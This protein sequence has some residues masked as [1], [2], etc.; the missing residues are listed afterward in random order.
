MNLW[1]CGIKGSCMRLKYICIINPEVLSENT[2]PDFELKYIDIGNVTV[3][4]GIKELQHLRFKDAPSR[5]R[6]VVRKGDTIVSTVRT[7]LRAI[8][9]IDS[10]VSNE[11]AS[12]GFAV[13]RPTN[14]INSRFLYRVAQSKPFVESVVALSSG[15]NYPAINSTT[16]A[17]IPIPLP[18]IKEQHQIASFLDHK[19]AKIDQLIQEKRELIELLKKKK[20]ALITKCVTKGLDDNVEM[21]DSGIEWIGEIP[22][23]WEVK[24]FKYMLKEPLRYGANESGFPEEETNEVRLI[25]ISDI[26][27]ENEIKNED[28]KFLP[29]EI[30][31]PYLLLKGDLLFA[32]SGATVGKSYLYEDDSFRACFAGYFIKATISKNVGNYKFVN[33]YAKSYSYWGFINSIFIQATIQNVSAEKYKNFFIPIPP[34]TEQN[35]IALFLD[36]ITSKIDQSIQEIQYSI[37]LLQK[38]RNS[39]ITHAVT[40]KIDVRDWSREEPAKQE[41]VYG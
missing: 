5:A 17:T 39:L 12:T 40:G 27:K 33:Y 1:P 14:R 25:R 26:N 18:G 32:R 3:E 15:V 36:K 37:E 35:E 29:K 8:A 20:T 19:I 31:K 6:K 23:H 41:A 38:Y 4:Q 11:I 2:A 21:K 9:H 22:A 13:L 28:K 7:Y 30:A 10:D 16:F 34:I 24:R